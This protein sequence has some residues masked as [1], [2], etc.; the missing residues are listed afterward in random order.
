MNALNQIGAHRNQKKNELLQ[1]ADNEKRPIANQIPKIFPEGEKSYRNLVERLPDG[2][3]K[4][5]HTGKFLE[6]N[7]A[8]V[9][10]LGYDSK[11]DLMSI[12]IKSELYFQPE[13]RESLVLQEKLEEMGIF[14][15][16]K[17]DGTEVWVEDHGWYTLNEEGEILF[18]EG[19]LRDITD[20]RMS[21]QILR[22]SERT[23][24][25]VVR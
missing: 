15:L 3:Y 1:L 20:R 5:T 18:H 17:K 13:D 2:V 14:M 4:S 9:K 8:M 25:N 19:I 11:E 12:D 23:F 24:Q 6:V 7:P 22:E 10:M 16:R 21:E